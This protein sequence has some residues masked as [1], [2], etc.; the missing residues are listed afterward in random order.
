M[1]KRDREREREEK[2]EAAEKRACTRK[3]Q[4]DWRA[5]LGRSG[6]EQMQNCRSGRVRETPPPP[7][8]PRISLPITRRESDECSQDQG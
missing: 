6:G 4:G 3:T 7:P 1:G 8:S 2:E 5:S